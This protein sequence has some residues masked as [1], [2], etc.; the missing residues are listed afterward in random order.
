M[1]R[2]ATFD[3]SRSVIEERLAVCRVLLDLDP[4]HSSAYHAE[5]KALARR[6]LL[7]RRIRELEQ[8]KIYVDL[9]NL[10]RKLEPELLELFTRYLALKRD[11]PEAGRIDIRRALIR[12]SEGNIDDIVALKLPTNEVTDLFRTMV[13]RVR[14][15]YVVSP[16]FG[17]DKYLSVRIRHGALAAHLRKAVE[18][19]HLMTTRDPLTKRH[20]DNSYW[21]SH[22][23]APAS[24]TDQLAQRLA[25]FASDFDSF[26]DEIK[27]WVRVSTEPGASVVLNFAL[28]ETSY[29]AFHHMVSVDTPY[30]S[31]VD[32]TVAVLDGLLDERLERMRVRL[33]SDAKPRGLAMLDQLAIDIERMAEGSCG[34]LINA[35]NPGSHLSDRRNCTSMAACQMRMTW[36]CDDGRCWRTSAGKVRMPPWRRS[37]I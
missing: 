23:G 10:R 22:L 11:R 27:S 26:V 4:A 25:V 17:L 16:E 28:N 35:I 15:E 13:N 5:I 20:R 34:E 6:L 1:D 21:P 2:T 24:F 8:S 14:D 37:S 12:A 30:Q 32:Q 3:S 29:L 36:A 9:D 18:S 19:A 7:A 31:F 33:D